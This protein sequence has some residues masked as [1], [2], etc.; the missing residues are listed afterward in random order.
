ME[1]KC[2]AAVAAPGECCDKCTYAESKQATN[3]APGII[4]TC[5]G[6]NIFSR[7]AS[8]T[9]KSSFCPIDIVGS[10]KRMYLLPTVVATA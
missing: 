5:S 3:S 4:N 7:N 1:C 2:P 6:Y 8:L 10:H 9:K